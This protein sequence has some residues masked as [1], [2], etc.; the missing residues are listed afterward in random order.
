MPPA[1][2]DVLV[3][4]MGMAAGGPVE[5]PGHGAAP[6]AAPQPEMPPEKAPEKKKS[7]T[8]RVVAGCVG[9][10]VLLAGGATAFVLVSGDEE[11][12]KKSEPK[13]DAPVAGWAVRAGRD[14]RA[15][16]GVQY[17]GTLRGEAGQSARVRLKVT[18][19][20]AATGRLAVGG[21]QF[22][23]VAVGG[24]TYVKA[25]TAFWRRYGADS[26]HP[27]NYAGRWSKA[28]ESMPGLDV[29]DVLAPE[30]IAKAVAKASGR[31]S[32]EDVGGTPAY[33]VKTPKADYF[34]SRSAP[35]RLLRVQ[36]AGN[37]DPALTV[38]R[39]AQ[40]A[41]V[42]T[43][44]R[45]RVAALVGAP[46]PTV[47]FRAGKLTFVNC[48]ENVS[49]CTV[50]VPAT[51]TVPESGPVPDGTR[52]ALRATITA[53]GRT[54]GGCTGSGAVP[55]NRSIVLRCTVRSAGWRAW[56]RQARDTPGEHAY[57]AQARVVGQALTAGEVGRLLA[58]LDRE[59]ATLAPARG[60]TPGPRA[61]VAVSP[62]GRP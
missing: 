54:L 29:A 1:P 35:H 48:N 51:M 23:V 37:G 47:R 41:P 12:Q 24:A 50:S 16:P 58:R 32:T 27:E 4:G 9:A 15:L 26:T 18:R 8:V 6:E 62:S 57:E 44:L 17:D 61:S 25:D 38:T 55:A 42:F 60:A 3:A 39:L 22:D 13:A 34:I 40:M 19:S 45:P 31:A 36:V 30:S 2:G 56:M 20:G 21:R 46:D 52:A 53:A 49:G 28:P 10:V 43:E 5:P 33:R 14:M 11:S 7:R 59:R